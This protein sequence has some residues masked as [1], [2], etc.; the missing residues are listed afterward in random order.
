MQQLIPDAKITKP[1]D[2]H[3]G[4]SLDVSE[5]AHTE[6]ARHPQKHQRILILV[7]C[8]DV[9]KFL[10]ILESNLLGLTYPK[11]LLSIG[12]LEGDSKDNTYQALQNIKQNLSESFAEVFLLQHSF[13]AGEFTKEEL[14]QGEL[15]QEEFKK[16]APRD[17]QRWKMRKQLKRRSIIAQVRNYLLKKCLNDKHQWVLWVD[18]DVIHWESD[19]IQQLLSFNKDILVP[20]CVREDN[21]RTFDLNSFKYQD[22]KRRNW[23]TYL[24][25]GLIQPPVGYGRLYL[26]DFPEHDL[27]SLDGLGGTMMLVK[28]DIHRQGLIYPDYILHKHIETEALAFMARDMGYECWGTPQVTIVHPIY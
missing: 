26:E 9:E 7:P 14:N 28:A 10:P 3:M 5:D 20:H 17:S 16:V 15:N 11:H 2:I 25:D 4:V 18:S 27:V 1:A 21:G 23:R 22:D 6:S 13:A 8:K 12:F 19:C 24:R